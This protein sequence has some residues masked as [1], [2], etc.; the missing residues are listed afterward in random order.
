M[1]SNRERD[2]KKVVNSV[3]S[4]TRASHKS[5]AN[6]AHEKASVFYSPRVIACSVLRPTS[7]AFFASQP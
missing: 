1:H 6:I 2:G 7:R 4:D 5:A 3:V